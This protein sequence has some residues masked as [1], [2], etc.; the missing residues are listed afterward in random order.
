MKENAEERVRAGL[1]SMVEVVCPVGV[2]PAQMKKPAEAGFCFQGVARMLSAC[3]G[4]R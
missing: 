3:G 2:V 4:R 1:L